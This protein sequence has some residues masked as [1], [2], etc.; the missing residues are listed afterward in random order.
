MV[1]DHY[2]AKTK[3]GDGAR[4][5]PDSRGHVLHRGTMASPANRSGR[6]PK[7][8][9]RHLVVAVAMDGQRRRRLGLVAVHLRL[10]RHDLHVDA[11]AVHISKPLAGADGAQQAARE[12]NRIETMQ[13]LSGS[14][15]V[16]QAPWREM[17]VHVDRCHASPFG[18]V[19][20]SSRTTVADMPARSRKYAY[21]S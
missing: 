6:R 3:T 13:Q 1:T 8:Q 21:A 20:A 17:R 2:P 12:G 10:W 7:N 11:V 4:H 18:E 16:R 5:L 19:A 9:L 14:Q 15:R